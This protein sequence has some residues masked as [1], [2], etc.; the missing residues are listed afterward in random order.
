MK[1]SNKLK[2]AALCIAIS[3][4]WSDLELFYKMFG[5]ED[6][7]SFEEWLD[8]AITDHRFVFGTGKD[9]KGRAYL[10]IARNYY[11]EIADEKD[12]DEIIT[13]LKAKSKIIA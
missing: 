8:G 12:W 5:T 9:R 11:N 3:E 10:Y 13:N 6:L 7:M 2:D 4:Y 1:L